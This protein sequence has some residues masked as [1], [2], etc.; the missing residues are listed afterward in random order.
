M[1]AINK[2]KHPESTPELEQ[3]AFTL[4]EIRAIDNAGIPVIEGYAAVF[5]QTSDDMGG[6][7]ETIEPG[8]FSEVLTDDVRSLWNHDPRFVLGRTKNETLSL[9][10]DGTGLKISVTPPSTQWAKDAVISVQRGDVDQMSFMFRVKPGGDDWSYRSDG[11]IV[12]TLKK[13]GCNNLYD[14]S[15]VTF[16]AYPQTSASVRSAFEAFQET[17]IPA[18]DTGQAPGSTEPPE[19]QVARARLANQKRRL[20]LA[21]KS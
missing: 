13:G 12:R 19:D 18:I 2:V 4:T 15:P 10:E 9:A 1:C 3:R 20:D 11:V 7:V 5:N 14:V 17:R 8:F 6:W 16:P 21:E